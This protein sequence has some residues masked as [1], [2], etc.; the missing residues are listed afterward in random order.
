MKREDSRGRGRGR[1]KKGTNEEMG[2]EMRED[3]E[4]E[5]RRENGR[6]DAQEMKRG[7]GNNLLYLLYYGTWTGYGDSISAG[8]G[9]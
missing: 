9:A 7:F 5:G 2:Q 3:V 1:L 8:G 6:R 4:R